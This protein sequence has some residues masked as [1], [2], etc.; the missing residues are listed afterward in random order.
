MKRTQPDRRHTNDQAQRW[1]AKHLAHVP[2]SVLDTVE[3]GEGLSVAAFVTREIKLRQ[4]Q[5][6]RLSSKF[7]V[8]LYEEYY[9]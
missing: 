7:K 3:N 6:G 4:P 5:K 9:Y 2:S 1:I 8:K